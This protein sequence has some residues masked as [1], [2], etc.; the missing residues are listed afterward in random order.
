VP[1]ALWCGTRQ[2][3]SP[4]IDRNSTHTRGARFTVFTDGTRPGG[5][6]GERFGGA[7]VQAVLVGLGLSEPD[8]RVAGPFNT[9]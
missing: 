7:P 5:S 9:S 6:P 4:D 8:V 2:E 3:R 1:E